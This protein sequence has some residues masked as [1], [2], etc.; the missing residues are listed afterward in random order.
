MTTTQRELNEM[1]KQNLSINGTA[2]LAHPVTVTIKFWN[3]W[4]DATRT[5]ELTDVVRIGKA[6][7]VHFSDQFVFLRI[8][9]LSDAD[10]KVLQGSLQ[11]T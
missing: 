11:S 3:G 2:K 7:V 6:G 4:K 9:E 10:C 5:F 8:S 1:V